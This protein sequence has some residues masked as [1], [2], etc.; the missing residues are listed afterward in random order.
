MDT[1][2]TPLKN[3]TFGE[4]ENILLAE[5]EKK[6]RTTQVFKWLYQ[7]RVDQFDQMTDMSKLL[8]EKLEKKFSLSKLYPKYILESK[9][10][11]AVKFG[12]QLNDSP[13]IIE[14]VLLSDDKRRT[15]CISSQVGCAL[16]CS[17][18]ETGKLGFIRN[19]TQGEIVGQIIGINDYLLSK[20]DRMVTNVV[21]MG[22]GEALSNFSNFTRSLSVLMGAEAFNIGGRRITVSTAG[23]VPSIE[24]LIKE[25]LN[26][27]LAISLNAWNN[28]IRSQFMPINR[29]FPIEQL[30]SVSKRYFQKTG[31][32]VTF[33]YILIRDLTDTIQAASKLEKMLGGFP[34]K[35]NLIPLNN[36]GLENFEPT[37]DQKT[38]RFSEE[39]HRR[40]LAA[41]IRKSRGRDI[42]GAC[43]QLTA[44]NNSDLQ[45]KKET[46]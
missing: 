25:G 41:T 7:K 27:G 34:C 45:Q 30:V 35:I 10:G 36:T 4:L 46:K 9:F 2:K 16:G 31:R 33:E 3:L 5:G 21:F 43:G 8:R 26:I 1:P 12:F 40:G 44:F 20:S 22:M 29:R 32:R 17:F 13:Y 15:A 14:S 19:L 42:M 23:V 37:A 39:L 24:R 28:E 11:D 18:C 38:I 6:F